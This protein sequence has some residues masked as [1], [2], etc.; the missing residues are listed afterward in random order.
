MSDSLM[1]APGKM[2]LI[3]EAKKYYFWGI[4]SFQIISAPP[5][6]Y[7]PEDTL[8]MIATEHLAPVAGASID[9]IEELMNVVPGAWI[10]P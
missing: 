8:E 5:Y 9:V 2:A 6:L 1:V 3:G 10:E 4:P 7:D